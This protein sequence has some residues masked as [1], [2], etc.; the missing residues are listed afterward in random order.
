MRAVR[1][2]FRPYAWLAL[3]SITALAICPTVSRMLLPGG[4][5]AES[6]SG[7]RLN[8]DS[9]ALATAG[10]PHGAGG[11]HDHHHHHDGAMQ[12]G[13]M[14]ASHAPSHQHALEQ[15]GFC[16]LAAHAFAVVP[17]PAAVL[18]SSECGRRAYDEGAPAAP[19]PRCDWSP[20]SSR[21]PPLRS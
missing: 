20:A 11:T 9:E 13:T 1:R 4:G 21:G 14:P 7:A 15:C 2:R 6:A 10:S 12:A 8:G 16:G 19:R 18:V 17:V 5:F 3:L